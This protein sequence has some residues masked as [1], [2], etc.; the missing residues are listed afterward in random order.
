[1]TLSLIL[2]VQCACNHAVKIEML[3]R[4]PRII[5]AGR[6]V[7]LYYC[8][9]APC[10]NCLSSWLFTVQSSLPLRILCGASFY[11]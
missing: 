6:Q 11:T 9:Q 2:Y 8:C 4:C 7:H 1:M 3:A 5:S 10:T